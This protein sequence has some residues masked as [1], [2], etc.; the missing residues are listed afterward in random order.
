[1]VR[2]ASEAWKQV[3]LSAG[4]FQAQ[5]FTNGITAFLQNY[6][7]VY[8]S[9]HRNPQLSDNKSYAVF[10]NEYGQDFVAYLSRMKNSQVPSKDMRMWLK[11]KETFKFISGGYDFDVTVSDNSQWTLQYT[12]P[13][14][15][16]DWYK[17]N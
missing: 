3:S 14:G 13:G 6:P 8:L 5:K 16:Y 17:A 12:S 9:S 11:L 4:G 10:P 7:L 2:I 15:E 1:M